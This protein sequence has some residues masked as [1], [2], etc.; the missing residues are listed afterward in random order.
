MS[1]PDDPTIESA[2]TNETPIRSVS[3]PATIGRYQVQRLVGRGGMGEVFLAHDPVLDREVAVK[4]ISSDLETKRSQERLVR[5]ARAAGR[6][7]HPNIVTIFDAGEH[8]GR[9]FIAM[10]YVRGETLA[11]LIRRQAAIPLSRRLELIEGACAGLAHAHRSGVVH[12]DIKP[13]NLMLDE[14]GT[15]KV[16][17]F[18][19]ARVLQSGLLVTR[20]L[21]GTLRYM[22]PEQIDG[23]PL[24][25]R[26]D[27]FSLGCAL[28][29]MITFVPAF[30]GSTKDIVSQISSGPVPAPRDVLPGLEARLDDIVLKAMALDATQRYSTLDELGAE[31]AAVRKRLAADYDPRVPAAAGGLDDMPTMLVSPRPGATQMSSTLRRLNSLGRRSWVGTLILATVLLGA[32]LFWILRRSGPLS[33]SIRVENAASTRATAPEPPPSAPSPATPGAVPAPIEERN[34]VRPQPPAIASGGT[35]PRDSGARAPDAASPVAAA[36]EPSTVVAPPVNEPPASP[37]DQRPINSEPPDAAVSNVPGRSVPPPI[38]ESPQLRTRA[39]E[40]AVRDTLRRYE[41]A[42]RALDINGVLQVYPSLAR[43]QADQL[44]RTFETV[45]QYEVDIRT[46]QIDVQ[47]DT[48]TV[49]A[50]LARRITPRV[51]NPVANEVATEFRL[52]RTGNVWSIVGLAAR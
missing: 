50:T 25:H 1:A 3:T 18:G 42:Y 11:S 47:A 27:V 4:L 24:D 41:A 26:S 40:D 51:G 44:R 48:A 15:V 16:L 45:T 28:F 32:S 17:D 22:S 5:E 12:L 9:P 49:R 6:L 33:H 10:E 20:Q 14:S 29:E 39:D 34:T 23:K 36:A 21:G 19:I 2:H 37:R 38:P 52:R 31:L 30:V 8:D 35:Q 46:S 7:R 43:D 13:D